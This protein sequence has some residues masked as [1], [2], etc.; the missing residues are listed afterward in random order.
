MNLQL[1]SEHI[2]A[3]AKRLGFSACGIAQAQPVDS[4]V[5]LRFNTWL[6]QGGH[7]EMGYMA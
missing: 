1:S 5:A 4:D 3:E 7:A 2:K 6:E